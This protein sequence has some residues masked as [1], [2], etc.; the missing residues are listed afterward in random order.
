MQAHKSTGILNAI[1][2]KDLSFQ[3]KSRIVLDRVKRLLFGFNGE[4][5]YLLKFITYTLLI[6]I[7]FVYVYPLLYM[8]VTSIKSLDDLLDLSIKW[9]P[10]SFYIDNYKQ[11]FSVMNLRESLK[12]SFIISL[13]PTVIQ[14]AICGLVGYGFARFEFRFKKLFMALMI[15]SFVL[16]PQ[17]LMMPTYSLFSDLKL[18]GSLNA[19]IIPAF[20][21][22]GLKSTIFIL[23]FFQFFKQTPNSLYEAAEVDGASQWTCFFRI[24]LPMAV[25]A[26]IVVFLFSFVWY[27]NETYLTTLYLTSRSGGDGLTTILLQLQQFEQNYASIYPV[28]DNGPNKL[29]EGIK[30]AGTVISLLPLLIVY[31]FLQKY[32]VESV[33]R[34]GITGE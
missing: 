28:T 3:E 14:V 11:A 9:L 34:T 25:P 16:P 1:Q 19:Y 27:W 21:G 26:V 23:I 17:I 6:C 13:V 20:L 22:Q 33:D 31:F 30:M 15:F 7:G 18:I 32:F 2:K 5:G 12:G 4:K 24:A 29:N 8:F 10:S